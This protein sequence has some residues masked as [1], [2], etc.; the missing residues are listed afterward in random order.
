MISWTRN[1]LGL[2]TDNGKE[3]IGYMLVYSGEYGTMLYMGY[4]SYSHYYPDSYGTWVPSEGLYCGLNYKKDPYVHCEG[5]PNRA[6]IDSIFYI[7]ITLN[8]KP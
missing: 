4:V 1:I 2:Y 8:P 6:N 3:D 5:S 7:Y